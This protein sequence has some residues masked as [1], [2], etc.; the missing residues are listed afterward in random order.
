MAMIKE[1]RASRG[2]A[3]KDATAARQQSNILISGDRLARTK[4]WIEARRLI[5]ADP[6]G[7]RF[8]ERVATVIARSYAECGDAATISDDT[9]LMMIRDMLLDLDEGIIKRNK[10]RRLP[11]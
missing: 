6:L 8:A 5:G 2:S 1:D 11:R 4:A 9:A 10:R 3:S 7:K